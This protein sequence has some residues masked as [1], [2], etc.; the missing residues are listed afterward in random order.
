MDVPNGI[1]VS[2]DC[3]YCFLLRSDH[4]LLGNNPHVRKT[5]S[6]QTVDATLACSLAAG[7]WKPKVFLGR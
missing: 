7:V 1:T 4:R 2:A 5:V 6:A 3:K